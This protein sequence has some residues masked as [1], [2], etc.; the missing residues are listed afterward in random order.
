M[1]S[2]FNKVIEIYNG[3]G[4]SVDLAAGGYILELYS[5]GDK[6]ANSTAAL[7]GTIADGGVYVLA[8]SQASSAARAI[9]DTTSGVVNCNGIDAVVQRKNGV[10]LDALGQVGTDPGSE[11]PGDSQNDTLLRNTDICA[12]DTADTDPFDASADWTTFPQGAFTALGMHT[13]DCAGGGRD[14]ILVI[15]EVDAN[16]PSIDDAEELDRERSEIAAAL[17]AINADVV[18]L[19]ENNVNDDAVTDLVTSLNAE[20]GAG[21][22]A[23]VE[24]GAI[25]GDDAIKL[26]FLY[27]PASVSLA[28]AY[29][30]LDGWVDP[31]LDRGFGHCDGTRTDAAAALVD[32][33][34]TD[35]TAR[36]SDKFLGSVTSTPTTRKTRS[37]P[38][39][40]HQV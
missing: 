38:W 1:G 40:R 33:L 7:T 11:W 37:T 19:I 23:A 17:A 24:T 29:A 3:T 18:G 5:N 12:G 10:V 20:V 35:P 21:T 8:N 15:N 6:V 36:G 13:A 14:P 2:S 39:L 26:A 4:A 25:G 28:G 27:K 34:A 31:D 9:A 16:T 32:W 30:L 22:Y